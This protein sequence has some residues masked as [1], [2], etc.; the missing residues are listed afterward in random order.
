MQ[1]IAKLYY[2]NV[3][4]KSSQELSPHCFSLFFPIYV[5]D[6]DMI[7]PPGLLWKKKKKKNT[8]NSTTKQ[9]CNLAAGP[10]T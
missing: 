10:D 2:V 7:T 9:A 3:G 6:Q 1:I 4:E 8:I 5:C